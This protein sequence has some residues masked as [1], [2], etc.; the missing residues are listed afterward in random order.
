[1]KKISNSTRL[2]I[3]RDNNLVIFNDRDILDYDE[4]L[5][6]I[7]S[8]KCGSP[9][10]QL[11][12]GKGRTKIWQYGSVDR[13]FLYDIAYG[14]YAGLVHCDTFADDMARLIQMKKDGNLTIEHLDNNYYNNTRANLVLMT[15]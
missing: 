5:L 9:Y 2:K 3:D 6:K 15:G 12:G 8:T 11:A 1:M 10:Q 14:C 4:E 7:L 13:C